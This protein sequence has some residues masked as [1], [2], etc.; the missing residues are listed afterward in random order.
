MDS[1]EL[2]KKIAELNGWT[3]IDEPVYGEAKS[4]DGEY[5]PWCYIPE[6][7]TDIGVAME[8]VDE[9][10]AEPHLQ[11][12]SLER[13]PSINP[14]WRCTIGIHSRAADTAPRAICLAFIAWKEANNG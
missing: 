8:L 14:R 1:D 3:E 4:P 11:V 13:V 9:A 10:Q 6:W 12:F 5:K 2:R 7:P